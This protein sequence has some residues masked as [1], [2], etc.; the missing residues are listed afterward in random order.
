MT[1]DVQVAMMNRKCFDDI[2]DI[3]LFKS[4]SQLTGVF[5]WLVKK[6]HTDNSG[7]V[8]VSTIRT[9]HQK[10]SSCQRRT[11]IPPRVL[12]DIPPRPIS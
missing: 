1:I 12:P 7:F 8:I 6:P 4:V 3:Q 2:F 5:F 10:D 9:Q 11:L